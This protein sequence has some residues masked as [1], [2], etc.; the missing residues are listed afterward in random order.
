MSF[1]TSKHKLVKKNSG[2]LRVFLMALVSAACFFVPYMVFDKGYFLF[3]GDYFD[4]GMRICY[5]MPI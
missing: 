5:N 3:F 2:A 1:I 4:S